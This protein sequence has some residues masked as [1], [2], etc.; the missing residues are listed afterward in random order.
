VLWILQYR[1]SWQTNWLNVAPLQF[2]GKTS[3]AMYLLQAPLA[4]ALG[5]LLGA[6]PLWTNDIC[7]F[8][9]ISATTIGVAAL[10]WRFLERPLLQLK[11]RLAP[12]REIQTLGH[13]A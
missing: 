8:V 1:S 4:G 3:Y 12:R 7:R 2:I 6:T 10:S 11:D 5:T 13:P 9:L